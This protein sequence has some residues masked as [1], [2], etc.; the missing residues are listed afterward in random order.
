MASIPHVTFTNKAKES[1]AKHMANALSVAC[2]TD[3]A[4]LGKKIY[5]VEGHIREADSLKWPQVPQ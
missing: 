2:A 3:Y 1:G 5:E 4:Y